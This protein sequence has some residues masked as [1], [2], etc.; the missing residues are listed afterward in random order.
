MIP[1]RESTDSHFKQHYLKRIFK[2][3]AFKKQVNVYQVEK[4]E[5]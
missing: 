5:K 1:F 2:N 4:D 3:K